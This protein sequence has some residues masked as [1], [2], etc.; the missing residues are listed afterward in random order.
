MTAD[1]ETVLVTFNAQDALASFDP[2]AA[3]IVKLRE[4]YGGLTINGLDDKVGLKKVHAARIDV[5]RVRVGVEHTRKRL[6]ADA[7]AFGKALDS[8][9]KEITAPLLELEQDLQA[10]EDAIAAE[11]EAIKQAEREAKEERLKER[12]ALLEAVN[13][14]ASPFMVSNMMAGE[15]DDLLTKATLEYEAEQERLRVEAQ[16]EAEARAQRE[17]EAKALDEQRAAAAKEREELDRAAAEVDRKNAEIQARLDKAAAEQR[18]ESDRLAQERAD[19]EHEK[20]LEAARAEAKAEAEAEAK[21]RE[22]RREAQERA[23]KAEA[24]RIEALKP[25][26]D[27]ILGFSQMLRDLVVPDCRVRDDIYRLIDEVCEEIE[28]MVNL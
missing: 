16:R 27:R 13:S 24:E 15:F 10:K 2:V 3:G 6:K 18:A 23:A 9:A 7:V 14:K 19:L 11:K 22:E 20:A 17:A 26:N 4:S 5:K 8:R 25:E 21:R 1:Q 12:M 28:G